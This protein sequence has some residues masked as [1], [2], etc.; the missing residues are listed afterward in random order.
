MNGSA[1]QSDIGA[2]IPHFTRATQALAGRPGEG[3]VQEG[4]VTNG[5]S[6][7]VGL[8]WTNSKKKVAGE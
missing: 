8:I 3:D 1:N 4:G 2:L 6:F 5:V 7:R